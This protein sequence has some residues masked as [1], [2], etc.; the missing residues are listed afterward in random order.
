MEQGFIGIYTITDHVL[1]S[2][3]T[4]QYVPAPGGFPFSIANDYSVKNAYF[5][6]DVLTGAVLSKLS[7]DGTLE[8]VPASI[9]PQAAVRLLLN[10]IDLRLD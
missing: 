4:K 2:A 8:I 7:P 10:I 5:S 3:Y 9:N 6:T 1:S